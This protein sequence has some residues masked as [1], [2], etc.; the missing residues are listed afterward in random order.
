[1]KISGKAGMKFNTLMLIIA[2]IFAALVSVAQVDN[3]AARLLSMEQYNQAKAAYVSGLKSADHATDWYYL[4]KIYSI[5]N[6]PDSARYCFSRAA[7]KEPKSS[8]ILVGQAIS[9]N[10]AGNNSQALLTLEKAQ[11]SAVS[12]KDIN[13]MSEIAEARYNAGDTLKWPITLELASGMD[14]KN[15]KPYITGGNLYTASGDKS[16]ISQFYGLATGR[17][18]QA[19][20]LQPDNIEALS[21]L[22]DINIKILNYDDAEIMLLKVLA[23]DSTYIPALK[24][25][26][27]LLY[28]LGRYRESSRYYGQY[29]RLAETN[30][31]DIMRFVNIL[32]F[33]KEY[34][35]AD[36]Y[37][38]KV[39]MKDPSNPV[40][41]RLKG[42]T[43]FELNQNQ[44]GLDAMRRFFEVRSV[45]DSSKVIA[46]DYEYYGKLLARAG[47]DSLAIFNLSKALETDP[48]KSDLHEDIARLYE[49]QKKYSEAIQSFDK[50]IR[51]KNENVTSL[52]YFSMGKDLL[53]MA[54][55]AK[56]ISDSLLH[57][58]YL[59]KAG[60]AFGKVVEM[61]PGSYLGY[62]WRARALA[63]TDPE[64]TKGLAKADYEKALSILESKNDTKKYA[65]DLIEAYRYLGYYYYLKYDE[66][67]K[68]GDKAAKEQA[69]SE[70]MAYWQK[71]IVIDPSNEVAKQALGA[72]K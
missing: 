14:K 36:G 53:L 22:A 35:V 18:H 1:M 70:S 52:V 44:E 28:S 58:T 11:R 39:L 54:D 9:E 64:T 34:S 27:E 13:A 60:S 31:K 45:V 62:Q 4:G 21:R 17:Y 19:L 66:I 25:M 30:E 12:A 61:S 32:Y 41:L 10:M 29:I 43:A 5:Q 37:I 15:P 68:S 16:K 3:N 2:F 49:K 38:D 48:G 46:S 65:S 42:Y 23:K 57:T 6:N 50:L 69:K 7:E 40:M 55:D 71:V 67:K 72:L 56:E 20:Y 8:L 24:S 33:N 63:G 26:G 47:N 59:Q 51:A